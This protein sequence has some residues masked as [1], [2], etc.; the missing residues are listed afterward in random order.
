MSQSRKS[1]HPHRPVLSR[2]LREEVLQYLKDQ[3]G[4][5][6]HTAIYI[7]FALERHE[8]IPDI[9]DEFFSEGLIQRKGDSHVILTRNGKKALERLKRVKEEQ[10]GGAKE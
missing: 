3:G 1:G 10:R 2:A 8:D 7:H 4:P 6:K 9:L 5:A